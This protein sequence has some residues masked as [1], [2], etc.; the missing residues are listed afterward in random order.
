MVS[1]TA[2]NGSRGHKDGIGKEAK[3]NNPSGIM[4][5]RDEKDLFVVDNGNNCIRKVSLVDGTTST[6]AGIPGIMKDIPFRF[7]LHPKKESYI[8]ILKKRWKKQE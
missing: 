1:T 7:L 6:I 2:G 8:I 5:S 3:F 4:I